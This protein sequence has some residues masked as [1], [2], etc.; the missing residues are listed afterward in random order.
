ML[1]GGQQG[2]TPLRVAESKAHFKMAGLLRTFKDGRGLS[3]RFKEC[4]SFYLDA[5]ATE[6]VLECSTPR[7]PST[8]RD[9]STQE[10]KA[11]SRISEC[12]THIL[13]LEAELIAAKVGAHTLGFKGTHE[14]WGLLRLL[15]ESRLEN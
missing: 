3:T 9:K 5:G 12:E 2:Q 4:D 7:D 10:L 14:L 15:S 8:Q 1:L 13:D 6:R 11:K